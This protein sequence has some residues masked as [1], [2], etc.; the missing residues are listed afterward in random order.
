[1]HYINFYCFLSIIIHWVPSYWQSAHIIDVA[2]KEINCRVD[3]FSNGCIDSRDKVSCKSF[4]DLWHLYIGCG[5][6]KLS[7]STLE[8]PHNRTFYG[9]FDRQMVVPEEILREFRCHIFLWEIPILWAFLENIVSFNTQSFQLV[10]EVKV[11]YAFTSVFLCYFEV[12]RFDRH[13]SWRWTDVSRSDQYII[14]IGRFH[15]VMTFEE[16]KLLDI[17]FLN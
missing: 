17:S 10:S 9:S 1:M 12:S 8:S 3:K 2:V 14:F 16:R 11:S 7:A 15:D 6:P 4:V 13:N 5:T